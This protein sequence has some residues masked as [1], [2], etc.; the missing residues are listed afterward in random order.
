MICQL[1]IVGDNCETN[2]EQ[3]IVY[4]DFAFRNNPKSDIDSIIE[5]VGEYNIQGTYD[6]PEL[7]LKGV[8]FVDVLNSVKEHYIKKS[9]SQVKHKKAG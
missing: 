7:N 2:K 9:S 5:D 8:S 1:L 3:N 6:V 4:L